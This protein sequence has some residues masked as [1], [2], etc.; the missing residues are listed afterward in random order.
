MTDRNILAEI[1][2]IFLFLEKF[3]NKLEIFHRAF[4]KIR[5]NMQ[6][7]IQIVYELL[8]RVFLIKNFFS[9]EDLFLGMSGVVRIALFGRRFHIFEW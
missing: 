2:L 9:E 6:F 4:I 1:K 8:G 5:I 3:N 7:L